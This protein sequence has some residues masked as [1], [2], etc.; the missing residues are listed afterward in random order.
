MKVT[1]WSPPEWALQRLAKGSYISGSGDLCL[2]PYE[3][4]GVKKYSMEVR[5]NSFDFEVETLA[6]REQVPDIA[7][8]P[9]RPAPVAAGNDD[10]NPPFAICKFQGA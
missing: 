6:D 1:I 7:T 3:K 8:A 9:R 2:R 10:S 5:C 4:E